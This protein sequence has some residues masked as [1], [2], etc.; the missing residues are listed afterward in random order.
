VDGIIDFY[1]D[2]KSDIVESKNYILEDGT[3]LKGP[4]EH[5]SFLYLDGKNIVIG[6]ENLTDK[7]PHG[8][9]FNMGD[10]ESSGAVSRLH[11]HGINKVFVTNKNTG[12]FGLMGPGD[13]DPSLDD[14][15]SHKDNKQGFHNVVVTDKYIF[16]YNGYK[17]CSEITKV[18]RSNFKR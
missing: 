10:A 6:C 5:G 8:I 2:N 7:N 13:N 9:F 1:D 4:A 3:P 12:Q 17:C 18:P 15:L 16:L 14:I 11:T